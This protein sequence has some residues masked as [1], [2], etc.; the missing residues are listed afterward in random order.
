MP[1]TAPGTGL[2]QNAFTGQQ[3]SS[4]A[5]HQDLDLIDNL[6]TEAE[7]RQAQAAVNPA[8]QVMQGVAQ[9]VPQAV[10]DQVQQVQEKAAQATSGVHKE[11][12]ALQVFENIPGAQVEYEKV[13]EVPPEV[14]EFVQEVGRHE[15]LPQEISI[16]GDDI[17]LT[18]PKR[19]AK[20]AVVV[21]PISPEVEDH[22]VKKNPQFSVRWLVEWAQKMMKMFSG[23]VI[24]RQE[25]G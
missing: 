11:A 9:A 2:L 6:I 7:G 12:E 15:Q 19:P 10:Q 25:E 5:P 3:N 20:K 16:S 4:Q 23:E 18:T 1:S 17:A 24:Y 21:L 14:E 22:G 13:S 8:Q